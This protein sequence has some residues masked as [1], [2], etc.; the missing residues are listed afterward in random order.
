MVWNAQQGSNGLS[1]LNIL[2]HVAPLP[3]ARSQ[4]LWC[5][6]A[7]GDSYR[8]LPLLLK[9]PSGHR[10]VHAAAHRHC[11]GIV[12]MILLL[13]LFGTISIGAKYTT[14]SEGVQPE[15]GCKKLV[16]P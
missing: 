3:L 6:E 8:L 10:T 11:N 13:S 12:Q 14:F 7:H 15:A 5:K 16:S 1:V 9:Q 4:I 2:K